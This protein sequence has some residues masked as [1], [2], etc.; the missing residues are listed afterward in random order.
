SKTLPHS[1]PD[2]Y[3]EHWLARE[4]IDKP[5]YFICKIQTKQTYLEA[6]PLLEVIGEKNGFVFLRREP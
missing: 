4:A 6:Y 1:N 5:A 2:H 3:T